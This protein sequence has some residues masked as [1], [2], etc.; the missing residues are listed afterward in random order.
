MNE[1]KSNNGSKEGSVV[2][3]LEKLQASFH[4]IMKNHP[5]TLNSSTLDRLVEDLQTTFPTV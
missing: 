2:I 5:F 1:G 3:S 4:E